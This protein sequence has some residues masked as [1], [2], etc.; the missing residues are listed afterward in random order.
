MAKK[1]IGQ[2]IVEALE[3]AGVKRCYGIPGD[4]LNHIID[5]V[6]FRRASSC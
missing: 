3:K 6:V 2:V 1:R 5:A 4:T